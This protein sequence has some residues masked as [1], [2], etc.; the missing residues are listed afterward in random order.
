MEKENP[1]QQESEKKNQLARVID[2]NKIIK[3][4]KK[5]NPELYKQ[6][7]KEGLFKIKSEVVLP[8]HLG[9]YFVNKMGSASVERLSVDNYFIWEI[10]M[11]L[12]SYIKTTVGEGWIQEKYEK[13]GGN[14][15]KTK[16][17]LKKYAK[18]L[19]KLKITYDMIEDKSF[20][21]KLK[22]GSDASE[23]R[24]SFIKKLRKLPLYMP[25]ITDLFCVLVNNTSAGKM[26]IPN[27]ALF[28]WESKGIHKAELGK[29][30]FI[31]IKTVDTK[32]QA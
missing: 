31:E 30:D 17:K 18:L 4:L 13:F 1:S 23:L 29:K 26:T 14:Y 10:T 22:P 19:Q 20:K 6:F 5:V 32:D 8:Y 15:F 21:S 24:L 16:K 27:S 3:R 12:L 7:E 25:E 2:E 11:I 28:N 9:V